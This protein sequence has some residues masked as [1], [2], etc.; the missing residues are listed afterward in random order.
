M[1]YSGKGAGRPRDRKE[2]EVV[3]DGYS[4]S[5]SVIWYLRCVCAHV[6][7]RVRA[8]RGGRRSRR[9]ASSPLTAAIG[10]SSRH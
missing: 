1:T 4:M 2:S 9:R 3:N 7:L 8:K 5:A 10:C 6:S